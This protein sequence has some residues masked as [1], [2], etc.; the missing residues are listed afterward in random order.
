M[1][2]QINRCNDMPVCKNLI[3]QLLGLVNPRCI[4]ALATKL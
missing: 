1:I 3:Q 4:P 2:G